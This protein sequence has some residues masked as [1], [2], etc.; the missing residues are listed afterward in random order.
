[1]E[2]AM[3]AIFTTEDLIEGSN[4][5]PLDRKLDAL[6]TWPRILS[7][8]HLVVNN[9][10]G[11]FRPPSLVF[12]N[13]TFHQ[14]ITSINVT[15]DNFITVGIKQGERLTEITIQINQLVVIIFNHKRLPI[16]SDVWFVFER[17]KKIIN[18]I[19]YSFWNT[20]R[21]SPF[22]KLR[23]IFVKHL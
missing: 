21:D 7:T 6:T 5:G 10:E 9:F 22:R 16:Q 17:N 4:S 18:S 14:A 1:M 15:T 23:V 8:Y 20:Y 11:F 3:I 13:N 2:L 19:I 12:L